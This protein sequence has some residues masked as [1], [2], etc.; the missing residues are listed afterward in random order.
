MGRFERAE[1]R[2]AEPRAAPAV[3]AESLLPAFQ[4]VLWEARGDPWELVALTYGPGARPF[5]QLEGL[6]PEWRIRWIDHVYPLDRLKLEEFLAMPADG[7]SRAAIEYR[8]ILASGELLWVRH[9][10]LHRG[11][12]ADGRPRLIGVIGVI[13]E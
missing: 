2:P 9:W 7:G 13:T 3:V 5:L 1:F 11:R 6:E 10:I 12:D 8:L 4:A